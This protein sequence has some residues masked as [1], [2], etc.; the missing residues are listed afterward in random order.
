ME[1]YVLP[2]P[3]EHTRRVTACEIGVVKEFSGQGKKQSLGAS[4][5]EG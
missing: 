5:L 3:F 2:R 4:V 1:K